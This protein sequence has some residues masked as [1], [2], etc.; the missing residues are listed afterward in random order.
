MLEATAA[1][2]QERGFHGAGLNEILARSGTPRGSLY[3]HFP[4]GKGQLV[5]EAT[6]RSVEVVTRVLEDHLA[7]GVGPVE[8][9]RRY[10]L[11]AAEEL[12]RSNYIVG[13]PVAPV[14]LDLLAD[15]APLVE[16]CRDTLR[17]WQRLLRDAFSRSGIA[18]PARAAALATTTVAA[19]EGG[20][21]LARAERSTL[22]LT[23]VAGEIG[24]AIQAA[25][26]TSP[27]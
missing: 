11:A 20:L 3:H 27:R 16:A 13:C 18:P 9:V 26:P 12:E 7:A 25:L 22:P 10:I 5:L 1:L 8:A 2:I 14:V 21:L 19:L 24:A 4:G 23:A 15:P 6:L 17:N